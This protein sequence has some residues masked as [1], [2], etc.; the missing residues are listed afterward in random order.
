MDKRLRAKSRMDRVLSP[1]GGGNHASCACGI[2]A[3]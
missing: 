1:R 2:A 3:G